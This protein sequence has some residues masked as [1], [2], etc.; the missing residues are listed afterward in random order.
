[1]PLILIVIVSLVAGTLDIYNFKEKKYDPINM[2]TST[3]PSDF[4]KDF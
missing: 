1:M 3:D 4:P 2:I